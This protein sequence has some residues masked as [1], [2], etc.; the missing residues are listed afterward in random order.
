[1][2]G[3]KKQVNIPFDKAVGKVKEELGKE[4]FGVLTEIDVK[5]TIKK[6]LNVD[7]S[8][9][10]IL[11][12]CNPPYAYQALQ[13]VKDVGLMMPCNVVVFVDQGK[14]FVEAV[15]PTVLMDLIQND[16]LRPIAEKIEAKL[17]KVVDSVSA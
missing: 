11:G 6:K 14:T 8:D 10:I 1:M 17:K 12:A 5:D 4:G 2:V 15:T 9:Y 7:F 16:N 13:I 3:Y